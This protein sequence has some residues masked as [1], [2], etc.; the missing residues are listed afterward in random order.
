M[1]GW[2]GLTVLLTGTIL[3]TIAMIN[4]L[5]PGTSSIGVGL[6]IIGVAL[7][8]FGVLVRMSGTIGEIYQ[9]GYDDGLSR[10]RREGRRLARPVLVNLD[11]RGGAD[12]TR[13]RPRAG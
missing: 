11:Q 3:T 10:G 4:D 1:L 6:A 5:N 12:E 9:T 7:L 2:A 8:M 13:R